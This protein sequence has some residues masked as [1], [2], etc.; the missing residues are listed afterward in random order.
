[1]RIANLATAG[2]P[3]SLTSLLETVTV[4]SKAYQSAFDV[5]TRTM[6]TTSPAGR[7]A[8]AVV[9]AQDRILQSRNADLNPADE[10]G[11]CGRGRTKLSC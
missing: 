8:T 3:L 5:A 9:D 6:T 2:D 11:P 1:V 4:N 10:V 7:K